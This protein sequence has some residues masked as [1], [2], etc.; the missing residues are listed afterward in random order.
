MARANLEAII[1]RVRSLTGIADEF[2]ADEI[3]A[4]LDTTRVHH[5][6]LPL[7]PDDPADGDPT[8][9]FSATDTWE[10][11]YELVDGNHDALTEATTGEISE[12]L[13]GRFVL[14]TA[15]SGPVM[16]TGRTYDLY[17]AAAELL[18]A[19]AAKAAR[20]FDFMSGSQTFFRSQKR[21]GLLALA[22]EFRRKSKPR[23]ASLIRP[24]E[25]S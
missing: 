22:A 12:P 17:A 6:Y 5:R 3:Q 18:T 11:G 24:D 20:D 13:V 19:W 14:A 15:F 23:R 10:D 21:A 16:I 7:H 1:E 8:V 9:W 2:T 4:A 25:D